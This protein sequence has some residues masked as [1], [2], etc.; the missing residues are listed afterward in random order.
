[1]PGNRGTTTITSGSATPAA[2]L[3]LR[4]FALTRDAFQLFR[5]R[6][7][8]DA[9]TGDR[10]RTEI[11]AVGGSRTMAESWQAFRGRDAALEPLLDAYGV[12]A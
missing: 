11:L 12:T 6:G 9:A 7:L 5:E 4:H 3:L 2:A 8:L 1:M 10:L